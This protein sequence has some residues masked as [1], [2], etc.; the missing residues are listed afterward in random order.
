VL[1]LFCVIIISYA[2]HEKTSFAM[3]TS[4]AV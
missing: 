2:I 4:F 3:R 1:A